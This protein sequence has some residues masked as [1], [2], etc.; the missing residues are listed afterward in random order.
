MNT[1]INFNSTQMYTKSIILVV[2][3]SI[4]LSTSYAQK[5][6]IQTERDFYSLKTISIPE[7]VKLEVGGIA[8]MPDGRIAAST[9]RG[10]IWIIENAYGSGAPHYTKFA[11]GLHE[12]LGLAYKDGAFYCMQRGELTKIEDTNNDG[13]ADVFTAVTLFDLSG[14]YHEYAYGPVFNQHGDMYVTLN[15]SLGEDLGKW[16]GWLLKITPE[17]VINPIAT[18]FRSPAGFTVNSKDEV[19]YADNQGNWVGSGRITHV[20]KGDFTGNPDGLKFTKETGSPLSLRPETVKAIVN[21][22]PMYET[23]KKIKELKLPAVWFPHTI[24]GISTSDILEDITNGA[25][26]PFSGQYF[27]ADQGHSKIMRMSLEKVNG[28]YQ[29]ACF[30]FFEGFSSGLLRLRW[31]LDNSIF[32]GMTSRGWASKGGQLYGLQRLVWNGETPFEMKNI[33]ALTDGF[34]VEFTTPADIIDLKNSMNYSIN[35]FTYKYHEDYGSPII[36]FHERKIIGIIPS[37]DGLKVKLILDSLIEGN[38]H[39]IK[40]A[41]IQSIEKLALLHNT[42]YY[43][44]NNIPQGEKTLLSEEYKVKMQHHQSTKIIPSKTSTVSSPK[45]QLKMPADWTQPD[46][47]L[48]ISTKPGLKF[49]IPMFEI[50]AGS[51]IRL[52]FN[53]NDDMMHNVVGVMPGTADEVADLAIKLGLKGSQM[54]YVPKSANVIFNTALLQPH[55]SESIYFIA[56]TKPGEYTFMCTY[57]GHGSV[58][59]GMLKVVQ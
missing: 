23:A 19:F 32:A 42:G 11:A 59:R 51:K 31:G 56:P 5:S 39:E 38:I 2:I 14:G 6:I 40:L 34:E 44:L 33:H 17:G 24:M 37:S 15:L 7:D 3:L 47:V 16:H 9:R 43:T 41:N 45:R 22:Q 49:D 53:N 12:I 20:E 29:G 25:F 46:M 50:K 35:S 13:K 26:G 28:K 18:G 4:I 55:S 21:G 10:E 36:N 1:K 48:K 52:V 54:N 57:P 27:V 30:P 58:M 8:V